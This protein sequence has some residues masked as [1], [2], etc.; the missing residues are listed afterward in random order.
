[1]RR[2]GEGLQAILG[3]M[4]QANVSV[5]PFR[6]RRMALQPSD[7]TSLGRN[8]HR[9]ASEAVLGASIADRQSLFE[10]RVGP[11]KYTSFAR[12]LPG[13]PRRRAVEDVVRNYAGLGLDA[14]LRLVLAKDEI[15]KASLGRCGTLGRNAWVI[16]KPAATDADDCCLMLGCSGAKS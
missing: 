5:V 12:L 4:L 7:R 10:V 9:L 1:M 8:S 15:P 16:S 14:R 3:Q 6:L 11:L 13:Q 2:N